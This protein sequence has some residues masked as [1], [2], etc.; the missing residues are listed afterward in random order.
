MNPKA[1]EIVIRCTGNPRPGVVWVEFVFVEWNAGGF[2]VYERVRE[3]RLRIVPVPRLLATVSEPLTFR[4]VL[5]ALRR[6]DEACLPRDF[7]GKVRIRG[8]EPWQENVIARMM[9]RHWELSRFLNVQSVRDLKTLHEVLG[10]LLSEEATHVLAVLNSATAADDFCRKSLKRVAK[11]V[12]V[13]DHRDLQQVI[14]KAEAWRTDRA[15]RRRFL[16]GFAR[17]PACSC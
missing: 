1:R 10:D 11:T 9:M 4:Q 2:S 7:R 5:K 12:G 6:F 17:G 15:A 16:A 14:D 13:P 3:K 8:V